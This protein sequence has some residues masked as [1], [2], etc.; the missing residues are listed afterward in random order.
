MSDGGEQRP[1]GRLLEE[2][3]ARKGVKAPWV[4]ERAGLSD[5]WVRFIVSGSQPVGR[6]IRA[7]VEAPADTLAR[8]ARV[9]DITPQQ[10][11]AAQRPDAAAELTVLLSHQPT[12]LRD[13]LE[14]IVNDPNCTNG[15]RREAAAY[16]SVL[17]A[18][19]Q[20]VDGVEDTR[21]AS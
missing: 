9:L 13:K 8:L 5:N 19:E 14:A 11:V 16:L 6:G 18:A 17:D 4:A 20:L 10:L 7:P 12:S 15:A 1:E 2:A 21:R 3:M